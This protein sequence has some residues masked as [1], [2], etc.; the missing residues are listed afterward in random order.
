MNH[1]NPSVSFYNQFYVKQQNTEQGA[2][3]RLVKVL[4][5][6]QGGET[7]PTCTR[8]AATPVRLSDEKGLI[9]LIHCTLS[10]NYASLIDELWHSFT[11]SRQR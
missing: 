7:L 4:G 9:H 2:T 3:G 5:I 1:T 11:Y 8:P 10:V 6:V